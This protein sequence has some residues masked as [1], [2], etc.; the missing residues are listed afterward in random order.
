MRLFWALELPLEVREALRS[1]QED[2]RALCPEGL[3]WTR[4]EALHLTCKFVGERDDPEALLAAVGALPPPGALRLELTRLGSF[5]G[6]RPRVVWAGVG[7]PDRGALEDWA[8]RLDERLAALGVPRE[9]RR[10]RP[11]VT[12]AR[13]KGR[14]PRPELYALAVDSI[15]LDPHPFVAREAVLFS[16]TAGTQRGPV[17]YTPLGRVPL[18]R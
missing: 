5:G 4:P 6:R 1:A 16:S 10:F 2:L 13:A 18:A 7:G 12:L 8:A 11:H 9:R 14:G 15:R 17:R 3:R